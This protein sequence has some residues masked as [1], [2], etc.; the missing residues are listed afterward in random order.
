LG[1]VNFKVRLKERATGLGGSDNL[2]KVS[3]QLDTPTVPPGF[4]VDRLTS[5]AELVSRVSALPVIEQSGSFSD[6][7][8]G[9]QGVLPPRVGQATSYTIHWRLTNST[10]DL[11]AAR[12]RVKLPSG[13]EWSGRARSSGQLPLPSFRANTREV[14]WD[15]GTV[16]AGIGGAVPAYEAWFQVTSIPSINQLGSPLPLV[17]EAVLEAKDNNTQQSILPKAAAISTNQL[18]DAPNQGRVEQ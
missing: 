3:V 16:P 18:I 12:W 5:L 14:I 7:V 4:A 17:G 2:I 1:A 9:S 13:V 11:S 15:L 6:A 10:G 8:F